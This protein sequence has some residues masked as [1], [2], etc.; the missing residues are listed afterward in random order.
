MRHERIALL[1]AAFKPTGSPVATFI[2]EKLQGADVLTY[3]ASRHEY[4]ENCV[5]TIV[6]QILDALQYLHWRGY[7][8]LDIQPDN[9][10]MATV[11]AVQIKLV[12]FGSAKQVTKLGTQVGRVGHPEYVSPEVL[13]DEPA[14]PHSDIWQVGVLTYVLLSGV[15]PFRGKDATETRQNIT[16]VRYR[17]EYLYKEL[18]QEATRFLMLVFKRSPW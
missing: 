16:F 2:L 18:T 17:F 1:E 5:A 12:D 9:V 10:V 14:Y 4:S 7:C 3:L 13:N 15:S 11:R 8:H 6:T